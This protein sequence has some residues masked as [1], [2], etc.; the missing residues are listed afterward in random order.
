MF[1]IFSDNVTVEA[2]INI[3]YSPRSMKKDFKIKV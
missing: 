3:T 2:H 1:E